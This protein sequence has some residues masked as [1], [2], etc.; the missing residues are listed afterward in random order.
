MYLSA[1]TNFSTFWFQVEMVTFTDSV[2]VTSEF[3]VSES[4]FYI[5]KDMKI[6]FKYAFVA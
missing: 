6:V 5:H 1:Y 4:T 3:N 2:C